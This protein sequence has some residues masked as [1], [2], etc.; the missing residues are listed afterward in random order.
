MLSKI[1]SLAS[2]LHSRFGFVL[3]YLLAL[4]ELINSLLRYPTLKHP[5]EVTGFEVKHLDLFFNIL[6]YSVTLL[7]LSKLQFFGKFLLLGNDFVDAAH[8]RAP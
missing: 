3:F 7:L 1:S 8:S 6:Q 4:E 5:F 2:L